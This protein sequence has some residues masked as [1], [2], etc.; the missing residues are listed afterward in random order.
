MSQ[1]IRELLEEYRLYDPETENRCDNFEKCEFLLN[2]RFD[3][4]LGFRIK[5]LNVSSI[6]LN[7]FR[8]KLLELKELK[9]EHYRNKYLAQQEI[10]EIPEIPHWMVEWKINIDILYNEFERYEP[11]HENNCRNLEVCI[12]LLN[13]RYRAIK[14]WKKTKYADILIEQ[15]NKKNPIYK[16]YSDKFEKDLVELKELKIEEY[17]TIFESESHIETDIHQKR[18]SPYNIFFKEQMKIIKEKEKELQRYEYMTAKEKMDYIADLW[19]ATKKDDSESHIETDI[20][21]KRQ[22]PYNIFFKEQMKIIKEK[23]KELQRYEYMTAKEKMDYIAD[24][25]K[26]T[27]KDDSESDIEFANIEP[28]RIVYNDKGAQ[29]YLEESIREHTKI[30]REYTKSIRGHIEKEEYRRFQEQEYEKTKNKI[31]EQLHSLVKMPSRLFGRLMSSSFSSSKKLDINEKINIWSDKII[32]L[33]SAFR[34]LKSEECRNLDEC[35]NKITIIIDIINSFVER[36]NTMIY[37]ELPK[38]SIYNI[39][40]NIIYKIFLID[41]KITFTDK[42]LE[43]RQYLQLLED[44]SK[45]LIVLQNIKLDDCKNTFSEEKT[46]G[47]KYKNLKSKTDLKNKKRNGMKIIQKY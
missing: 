12:N 46:G 31:K 8:K 17:R 18:Q 16:Y 20:H 35:V 44:Y 3:A 5:D 21:Q 13:S 40:K 33:I 4:L 11:Y 19:K 15:S 1:K 32:E 29:K 2:S 30:R 45:I 39:Q 6:H 41:Y 26:A 37:N 42:E 14:E 9:I 23:E 38:D 28:D 22:S 7:N 10:Q 36:P 47:K 25:W 24:L 27:K 43:H 34:L